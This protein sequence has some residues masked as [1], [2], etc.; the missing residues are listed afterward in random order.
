LLQKLSK[1]YNSLYWIEK[2]PSY[3][4]RSFAEN[5]TACIFAAPNFG[6]WS[7]AHYRVDN[8]SMG[9]TV[10]RPNTLYPDHHHEALEFYVTLYGKASW[11]R[12]DGPYIEKG[13]D[14]IV[15]HDQN[16]NHAIRTDDSYLINFYAWAGDLES[17][18]V[19]PNILD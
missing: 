3:A 19:V 1:Q 6:F 12:G 15:Y 2:S 9:F 16:E 7:N 8:L 5:Y 10:H 11:R 18:P 13:I 4:G 14:T 17:H